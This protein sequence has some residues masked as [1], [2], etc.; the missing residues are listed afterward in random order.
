MSVSVNIHSLN[1][2]SVESQQGDRIRN[3]GFAVDTN[4]MKEKERGVKGIWNAI[5]EV[6][7][8]KKE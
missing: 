4:V 8:K 7:V 6:I 2:H 3:D 5:F 1:I